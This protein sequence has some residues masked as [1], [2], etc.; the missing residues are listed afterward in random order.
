MFKVSCYVADVDAMGHEI[1]SNLLEYH[2]GILRSFIRAL[3]GGC[4]THTVMGE[5]VAND[6][7]THHETSYV[8]SAYVDVESYVEAIKTHCETTR[9]ALNLETI[10]VSVVP[11]EF[12]FIG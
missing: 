9:N 1:D 8:V 2:L 7:E 10:L 3:V 11:C 12:Y 4:S 5:Y 6:G